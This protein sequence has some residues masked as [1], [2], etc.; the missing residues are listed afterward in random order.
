M[1][2]SG[3][4]Q[5]NQGTLVALPVYHPWSPSVDLSVPRVL[6]GV[7]STVPPATA[8]F[9]L[10]IYFERQSTWGRDREREGGRIPG[11]L[12]TV[13]TD[14]EIMIMRSRPELKSDA[15]P[16]EPPG[17]LYHLLKTGPGLRTDRQTLSL[18]PTDWGPRASPF[19]A[20]ALEEEVSKEG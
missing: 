2:K 8:L 11:R 4:F 12:Y 16:T 13:S 6:V 9:S 15:Q 5:A 14:H 7:R 17:A 19:C 18:L 1:L 20:S 10:F 3:R